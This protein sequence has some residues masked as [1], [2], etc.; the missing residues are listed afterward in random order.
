[1]LCY[2]VMIEFMSWISM[3]WKWYFLKDY[4]LYVS[5]MTIWMQLHEMHGESNDVCMMNDDMNGGHYES[6]GPMHAKH[7]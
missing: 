6:S 2:D 5:S 4:G 3:P 1:M 7:K